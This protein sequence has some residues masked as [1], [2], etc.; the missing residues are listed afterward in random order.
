MRRRKLDAGTTI[1]ESKRGRKGLNNYKITRKKKEEKQ[2]KRRS[3]IARE[4]RRGGNGRSFRVDEQPI[5]LPDELQLNHNPQNGD[6]HTPVSPVCLPR[7]PLN[8][9]K[10]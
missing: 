6:K 3:V 8:D 10:H 9:C 2:G 1:L 7:T 4:D 5:R